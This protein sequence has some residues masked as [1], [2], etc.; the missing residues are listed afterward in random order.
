MKA[1]LLAVEGLSRA[2]GAVSALDGV[3]FAVAPRE[4]RAIIGPNG[5]G[6]TTLFNV[7]TGQLAPTG[8]EI[9]LEG[10]PI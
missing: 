2:F 7:I 10:A 5:A 4:R 9:R 3:S 1:P 6:K 8:G